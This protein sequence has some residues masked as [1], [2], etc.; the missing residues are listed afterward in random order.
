M[1]SGGVGAHIRFEFDWLSA[2]GVAGPELA[3][4]MASLRIQAGESTIT[5]V[6]DERSRTVR[7]AVFVPLYPLAEWL[8]SNWWFLLYEYENP[9][10][11]TDRGFGRRHSMNSGREGY[12]YP[13]LQIVSSGHLVRLI[14]KRDRPDWFRYRCLEQ[15]YTW[16]DRESWRTSSTSLIDSVIARLHEFH[17]YDTLLEQDWL[18]IKYAHEEEVAFCNTA[19]GLGLD[20]YALDDGALASVMQLGEVATG[21]ALEEAAAALSSENLVTGV[22]DFH[23]AI[24]HAK[25]NSLGL[26]RLARMAHETEDTESVSENQPDKTNASTWSVAAGIPVL[27]NPWSKGYALAQRLRQSLALDSDPLPTW[28]TIA[29]AIGESLE[30]VQRVNHPV[31]FGTASLLEGVISRADDDSFAFAFS[32]KREDSS[33]R[34]LFCS[35]LADILTSSAANSV[36][37][38]AR[39]WRQQRGR[40]FAAEF[41]APACAIRERLS[42]HVVLED[43]IDLLAREFGVSSF[44]IE[45]QIRNHGIAQIW[46]D[47]RSQ[48]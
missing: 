45:H 29:H 5:R 39:S 3:A 18:T 48:W 24:E 33:K 40:A 19:A 15:G 47:A 4:T 34:F 11:E 43:D 41:L 36:L 37:T 14:W 17:I 25:R 6:L 16:T 27:F 12:G 23:N 28:H 42:S 10:K 8:V 26:K 46:S 30:S 2:E 1:V 38:R 22:A 7:D 31:S 9:L 32:F 21:S 44:V 20:P 35:A 13:D